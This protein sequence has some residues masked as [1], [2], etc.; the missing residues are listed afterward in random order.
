MIAAINIGVFLL[1]K[2]KCELPQLFSP[3]ISTIFPTVY[4]SYALPYIRHAICVSPVQVQ[5]DLNWIFGVVC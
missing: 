3:A 1:L 4:P 5:T 2:S